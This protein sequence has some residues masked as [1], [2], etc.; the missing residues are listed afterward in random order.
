MDICV[1]DLV[2][3]KKGPRANELAVVDSVEKSGNEKKYVALYSD[4]KKLRFKDKH[5]D[6][7]I[8]VVA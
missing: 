3:V 5:I 2:F 6:K 4:G 1:D 7:T 8:F